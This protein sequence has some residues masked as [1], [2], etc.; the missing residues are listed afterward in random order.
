MDQ[1]SASASFYSSQRMSLLHTT[2]PSS[3]GAAFSPS[4][5]VSL[6]SPSRTVLSVQLFQERHAAEFAHLHTHDDDDTR[7]LRLAMEKGRLEEERRIGREKRQSLIT[8]H[9][10]IKSEGRSAW[11]PL[12]MLHG[13]HRRAHSQAVGR[14]M[15]QPG[16]SRTTVLSPPMLQRRSLSDAPPHTIDLS[17]KPPPR[18]LDVETSPSRCLDVLIEHEPFSPPEETSFSN[19]TYSWATQFS[20]E[21]VEL[22]TAA[23][24]VP[25]VPTQD[26]GTEEL[27]D[28]PE[29]LDR[30]RKR[31]VAIAHTVRQLEGIGS[32]EKEDPAFF[33]VIAKAWYDRPEKTRDSARL[34][35]LLSAPKLSPTPNLPDGVEP[36]LS[37]Y[38]EIRDHPQASALSS[39]MDAEFLTPHLP[40]HPYLDRDSASTSRSTR[41]SYAS[42]LHDLALDGGFQQGSKLMSEKAWLRRS[43][44]GTPWGG[45]IEFTPTP[46][47]P[48]QVAP[49]AVL[50][51][52]PERTL[53]KYKTTINHLRP[54]PIVDT[55]KAG[56]SR[57]W[58]LGFVSA[59]WDAPSTTVP[60][61][62]V[63]QGFRMGEDGTATGSN[64]SAVNRDAPV[65]VI[66]ARES[67]HSSR[68]RPPS[69]IT[70]ITPPTQEEG[71]AAGSG[72]ISE[73][74]SSPSPPQIQVIPS[75]L[76]QS[77]SENS[78]DTKTTTMM[79][80]DNPTGEERP[81]SSC[82]RLSYRDSWRGTLMLGECEMASAV[83]IPA[84]APGTKSREDK[85]VETGSMHSPSR[86]L[87][88]GIILF[89]L[90]FVIPFLWIVGGWLLNRPSPQVDLEHGDI[91]SSSRWMRWAKYPDPWVRRCRWAAVVSLPL[92]VMVGV[93]IYLALR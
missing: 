66:G 57:G 85:D 25:P 3:S 47:E 30:R 81:P 60:I 24:Y 83:D 15:S 69:S 87:T 53:R 21:T 84:D 33:N 74:C 23:H 48:S 58:G 52:P 38:G 32:R 31:I 16:R 51:K 18:S 75:V 64:R 80:P 50:E 65:E 78:P 49:S 10:K 13:S 89:S 90:G 56:P 77:R 27:L 1:R 67:L 68:S 8:G 79:S 76:P 14:A 63:E 35:V 72:D 70:T 37:D 55:L 22:R 34:S 62:Q 73:T 92:L 7:R 71:T 40:E 28:S 5:D 43:R 82:G 39:P 20:G 17:P 54:D 6:L 61:P 91:V 9:Q 88:T 45:D 2:T 11:R 44:N 19:S 42:T 41:Y 93:I 86:R 59:W 12:S 29:R 4:H 26:E 46:P 36:C